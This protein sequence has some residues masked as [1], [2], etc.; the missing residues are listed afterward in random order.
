[1]EN[2]ERQ[3]RLSVGDEGGKRRYKS[4]GKEKMGEAERRTKASK[5]GSQ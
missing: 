3:K 4:D 5:K 2:K 1:M